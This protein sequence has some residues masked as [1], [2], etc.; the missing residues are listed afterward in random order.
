MNSCNEVIEMLNSSGLW[1]RRGGRP[2]PRWSGDGSAGFQ[3]VPAL[4]LADTL[5]KVKVGNPC[6]FGSRKSPPMGRKFPSP[7]MWRNRWEKNP[8]DQIV[9]QTFTPGGGIERPKGKK[10]LPQDLE[11]LG[12]EDQFRPF[13]SCSLPG[14]G[15][16]GNGGP[17]KVL[18]ARLSYDNAQTLGW[19]DSRAVSA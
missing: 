13:F 3:W 2:K 11:R 7:F 18:S 12:L 14:W 6:R 5:S 4:S 1:E 19:K 9:S 15:T 8:I 17:G 10:I 16:G